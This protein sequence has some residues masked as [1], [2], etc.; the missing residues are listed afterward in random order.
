MRILFHDINFIPGLSRTI[1]LTKIRYWQEKGA[2]I[3]ICCTK[4]AE[5]FYKKCLKNVSF[6][7]LD[8]KYKIRGVYSLIWQVVK[9]NFLALL[10]L[11]K[12]RGK[13]DVVYSASSVIDFIFIP[14]VLKIMDGKIK[15]FVVVDNLVPPPSQRPGSWFRNTLPYLAFLLGELMLKKADG[16][17]VATDFL[18]K[19]Y[20]KRGIKNVIKTGKT[21][22][23][24]KEIFEGPIRAGTIKTDALYCG[25]LHL[26]KGIFDLV[27]VVKLI[28]A[29]KPSFRIGILGDGEE[30]IK[31]DFY[32][33][34]KKEGLEKNFYHFGYQTGKKKGDIL[35]LCGFF[36]FLSYDE[37]LPHAVVEALACN[38]VI[39]AYDL[40]IYHEV[41]AQYLKTRQMIL[42]PEKD[43]YSIA[44]FILK[45]N[46]SELHFDNKLEDFSWDKIAEAELKEMKL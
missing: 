41:F 46:F 1:Y 32:I 29:R 4:D 33:R 20:R 17:F 24:E 2:E 34:I 23:I 25:R 37:G 21:L 40:P 15:W 45:T 44:D 22:G 12:I 13:F 39:V 3:G 19:H 16:I 42:F 43:F 30:R 38:K 5:F 27:D 9:I 14:W 26:A 7:P 11:E 36:S 18:R 35:R 31:K 28:V 10:S 6:F 8:F